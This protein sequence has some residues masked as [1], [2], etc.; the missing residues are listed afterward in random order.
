MSI[1]IFGK[2][3]PSALVS[4]ISSDWN[5]KVKVELWQKFFPDRIHDIR[6][7]SLRGI[8]G[9][10][11]SFYEDYHRQVEMNQLIVGEYFGQYLDDEIFW[12]GRKVGGVYPGFVDARDVLL[13][14]EIGLEMI[15]GLYYAKNTNNPSLIYF[16]NRLLWVEISPDID[17]FLREV[18]MT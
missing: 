4:V 12:F 17:F 11:K 13:I 8:Q 10:T 7:Y 14:G 2:I 1:N 16:D 18:K 3:M 15:F 9:E 6:L 5:E